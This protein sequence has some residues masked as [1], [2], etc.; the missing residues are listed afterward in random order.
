[1][2]TPNWL[3]DAVMAIPAMAAVRRAFPEAA[4]AVA[5]PAAIVPI[6][7]EDTPAGPCE[8]VPVPSDTPPLTRE[9]RPD[10]ILLLPN[11]FRAAWTAK[12]AGIAERWGYGG[13]AR[14]WLLT[15][16]VRR[17]R[18]RLHQSEFY[19]EL[20]RGLG[21]QAEPA[22]PRIDL[23]AIVRSSA[24]LRE[25]PTAMPNA[26]RRDVWRSSSPGWRASVTPSTSLSA[27]PATATPAVR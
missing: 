24:M 12:R 8:I 3:G 6:F 2:R 25:P 23:R 9:G 1:M 10:A 4:I 7:A 5:G 18:R 27:R 15:R 16:P 21:L 11:S 19:L 14:G 26:G 22:L 13:N 20:V 17:P